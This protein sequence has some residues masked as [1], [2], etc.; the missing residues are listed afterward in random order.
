MND[1]QAARRICGAL[2][3]L[4]LALSCTA[5]RADGYIRGEWNEHKLLHLTGC[6]ALTLI[7]ADRTDSLAYGV[8]AATAVAVAREWTKYKHPG[9]HPSGTSMLADAAGIALAAY[10]WKGWIVHARKDGVAVS[11]SAQF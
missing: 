11:Y 4:L 9:W 3:A 8:A 7:V 6:Y 2:L 5:S 10:S 1:K